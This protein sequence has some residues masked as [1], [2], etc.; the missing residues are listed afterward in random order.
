MVDSSRYEGEVVAGPG[1]VMTDEVGVVTG[2]LTI[3]TEV[4]DDQATVGVQY[5]GADEWYTL[6]GSPV[7]LGGRSGREVHEAILAAVAA[8]LPEGLTVDP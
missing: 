6:T 4:S 2:D 7:P 3:R 5:T 1:E 8:G